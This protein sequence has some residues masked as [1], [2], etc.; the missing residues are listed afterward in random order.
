MNQ[1][2]LSPTGKVVAKFAIILSFIV[3]LWP[4]S[5]QEDAWFY[6]NMSVVIKVI[7]MSAYIVWQAIWHKLHIDSVYWDYETMQKHNYSDKKYIFISI[8]C[9]LALI[10]PIIEMIYEPKHISVSLGFQILYVVCSIITWL[11][12]LFNII[13]FVANIAYNG[14]N[15]M[16][17]I[18]FAKLIL[19]IPIVNLLFEHPENKEKIKPTKKIDLK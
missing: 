10:S 7:T 13:V 9:S 11:I 3:L 2:K 15:Y 8:I 17:S 5:G 16:K 1:L 6:N 12:L 4:F 19:S 18:N 14:Y